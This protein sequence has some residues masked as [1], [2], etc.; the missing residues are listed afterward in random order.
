MGEYTMTKVGFCTREQFVRW[1]GNLKD[2]LTLVAP[3]DVQGISLYKPIR[4]VATIQWDF[5][6]PILSI[7]EFFFP[8][9]ER[10]MFIEKFNAQVKV[11][12]TLPQ[13]K[14]VVFGVRPC[15][16]RGVR[17]L[18]AMFVENEPVDPYYARRRENTTLIGLTCEEMGDT[19]FCTQVGGS[20][21]EWRDMDIAL[22]EVNGG[23]HVRIV[24]DKGE[25]LLSFGGGLTLQSW[26]KPE[27]TQPATKTDVLPEASVW[28]NLFDDEYWKQMGERC[29]SCR[30]C[31]YVCPT[32]RCF[33]IRD[34]MSFAENGDETYERLRCWDS[35][36]GEAYRRIA[37][38]HNPR[39]TEGQ[40]LRNRFYCKFY[41]YPLQ[42]HLRENIACTGC[43]RCIDACP[44]NIDITEVLQHVMEVHP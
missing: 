42:Y 25:R 21:N 23:Y 1:L 19:C 20:P 43:G 22:T 10:L 34:E 9:T 3:T 8:P 4:D 44:V 26:D 40:R 5:T 41:Y 38:G 30:V 39:P 7:K 2:E 11:T 6:R 16:A 18:D 13:E 35:C 31:A 28:Q 37:G 24:T 12:E 33:D 15:D 36:T 29:L 14:T 32:C 17:V 27:L